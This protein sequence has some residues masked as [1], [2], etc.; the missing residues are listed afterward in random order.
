MFEVRGK[1][2]GVRLEQTRENGK[3]VGQLA[4]AERHEV[5]CWRASEVVK[6]WFWVQA[7]LGMNLNMPL[8]GCEILG[9]LLNLCL[10][11]PICRTGE[12]LI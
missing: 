8:T 9:E 5:S 6:H 3:M 10:G 12:I 7:H 1:V 11:F 4:K 2:N